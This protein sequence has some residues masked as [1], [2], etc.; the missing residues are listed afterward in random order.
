MN[1]YLFS[2][3]DRPYISEFDL[4]QKLF[5]CLT[6]CNIFPQPQGNIANIPLCK[7]IWEKLQVIIWPSGMANDAGD[8]AAAIAKVAERDNECI[9]NEINY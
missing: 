8:A 1:I 9:K 2:L 6:L 5:Y 7:S 4:G 3:K